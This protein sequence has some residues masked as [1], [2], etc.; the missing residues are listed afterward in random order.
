M[1]TTARS[2][3]PAKRY[4]RIEKKLRPEDFVGVVKFCPFSESGKFF[5]YL[6]FEDTPNYVLTQL[7]AEFDVTKTL[8]HK[9]RMTD[10]QISL[11]HADPPITTRIF[12]RITKG[13]RMLVHR[14]HE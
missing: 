5:S 7:N 14:K 6:L 8:T 3:G 12:A 1:A 9:Q 2:E 11:R 10:L 13:K 4:E